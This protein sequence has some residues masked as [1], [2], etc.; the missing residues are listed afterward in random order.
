[1]PESEAVEH[2]KKM[3]AEVKH[4]NGTNSRNA[5]TDWRCRNFFTE[6]GDE[7]LSVLADAARVDGLRKLAGYVENGTDTT[8]HLFQ[9]DATKDWMVRVGKRWPDHGGSLREAIDAAIAK[10]NE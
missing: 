9:D 6:Y 1:M 7:L 2:F 8:V 3:L 10:D 5:G 4:T